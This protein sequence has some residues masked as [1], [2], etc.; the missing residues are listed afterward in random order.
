MNEP[1]ENDPERT[2]HIFGHLSSDSRNVSM[3][4]VE[5]PPTLWSA[6][7]VSPELLTRTTRLVLQTT[8]LSET[9]Q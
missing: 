2:H 8:I 9:L 3:R 5:L 1:K 4:V 6:P 7:A